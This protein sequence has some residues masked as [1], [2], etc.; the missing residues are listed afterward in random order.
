[1]SM[2]WLLTSAHRLII[3]LKERLRQ[4]WAW[5]RSFSFD[6]RASESCGI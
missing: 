1:M 2:G 4:V 5:N 6:L 3:V